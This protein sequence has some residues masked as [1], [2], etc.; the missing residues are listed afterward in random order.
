MV[1]T[2][3]EPGGGQEYDATKIQVLKGL[4]GV[5]K[6]PA[7][8]IGSTSARGL[9]HLVYEVVD[10]S[11][12]EVLA[13]FCTDVDV[14]IHP[15]N[16]ITVRDNGRGIP[17]DEHPVQ[18]RP[19]VEVVMT[20]LHA[21]GKFDDKSYKVSGGLHGVGVSVV[22]AL[23]EWLEVEVRRDGKRYFQ[24]YAR[25]EVM[26]D[27]EVIGKSEETGTT[28]RFKPDV[29]IFEE[30]E[31]SYDTLSQRLRELAFL[32]AG[33]RIRI[34]DERS[35]KNHEFKFD[36]G[37]VEFVKSLNHAKET[38]HPDPIYL[39]KTRDEVDVEVAVQYNDTFN[40][41]VFA[42][43]NNIHTVEGGTHLV[44]FKAAL[45]RTINNYGTKN[46]LF[47]DAK[48]GVSGDDVREGLTAVVSVK[49]R[50]PQFEGQTKTKLG[51]SDV[52]GI[53][54]SIVGEALN[55][56]FEENPN[57][58]RRV[59]E[60]SLSAARAREAARKA[61]DLA[62]RKSLLDSGSLPG[63]L[64]DC[65]ERDPAK[66]EIFLVEGDS[67]G[68][69]A[70]MGRDRQYQAILPLKGK[71]LNVEKAR[72]DK[73]LANEEIKVIITAL[74]TSIGTDE[75]NPDKCRYHRII[76]MSDADV[77]GS[78]IRTLLLTFFFRHMKPLIE[79]GWVYVAQPPL[80]LVKKGKESHYAWSDA[81]RDTILARIGE[82][83]L[84]VQRYKG[85]GEMNPEQLWETTMNPAKRVVRRVTMDDLV[86]AE[87]IFSTLMGEAVEP[88]RD[89][90][91]K[92]ALNVQNLDL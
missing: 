49:L 24:R 36:G 56:Y 54:E 17:V 83:G 1:E 2:S 10:N 60:K 34:T 13:G 26:N 8:Y 48:S 51:N 47:R 67:A 53:V 37:I 86:A 46:G 43:V 32:N 19:A 44:G 12:D 14:T 58:A 55:N 6:R 9:H 62:R 18:G 16:S 33:L 23:S 70:K 69:S 75:F 52:K 79:R 20:V 5:R 35:G 90:I 63:K 21:G 74:G 64:A 91:Y 82:K 80:Y 7:M 66:T 25:G 89:F 87:Q 38:L 31:Y 30:T 71:I 15:D 85:L 61:R 29:T 42:Y 76:L 68:G 4:E 73:M 50:D 3:G 27:L 92:N 40:E 77:D 81:E 65:A 84:H 39:H 88:R 41:N 59:M 78:H 45:T 11:V 22:N 57:V 28:V 72:L